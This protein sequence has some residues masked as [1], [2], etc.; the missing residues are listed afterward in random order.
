MK[1]DQMRIWMKGVWTPIKYE[2][3]KT[4]EKSLEVKYFSRKKARSVAD[5]R[6]SQDN[7]SPTVGTEALFLMSAIFC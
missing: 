7:Y 5:R 3:I 6:T 2:D 1:S 4:K